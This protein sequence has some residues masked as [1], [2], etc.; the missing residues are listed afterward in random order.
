MYYRFYPYT[1]KLNTL[2]TGHQPLE[3]LAAH[4]DV[5]CEQETAQRPKRIFLEDDLEK[6]VAVQEGTRLGNEMLRLQGGTATHKATIR[7]T[8]RNVFAY[9]NGFSQA[10]QSHYRFGELAHTHM[11]TGDVKKC[12]AAHFCLYPNAMMHFAHWVHEACAI[13]LL[14][15]QDES[16]ILPP[17]KNWAH[18]AQYA[19]LFEITSEPGELFFVKEF[20]AYQDFSQNSSKAARYAIMRD[21]IRQKIKPHGNRFIYLSRGT[22]GEKRDIANE[23]ELVSF[24]ETQGFVIVEPEKLSVTEIMEQCLGAEMVVSMEGSQ[25]THAAFSLKKDGFILALVPA[26]RFINLYADYADSMGLH[27][28]MCLVEGTKDCGYKVNLDRFKKVLDLCLS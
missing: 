16:V 10:H 3:D 24:L 28:S 1:A 6:I 20:H 17:R 23:H 7:Y 21:R 22:T 15:E 8:L 14:D 25:L 18:T 5:L 27:Y 26:D 9:A 12:D 13:A 2:F 11:L 4:I 19:D